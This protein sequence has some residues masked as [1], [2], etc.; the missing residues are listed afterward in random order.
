MDDDSP[1]EEPY[2]QTSQ[3]TVPGLPRA[4]AI[5]VVG[6]TLTAVA[7]IF[8]LSGPA[9][10][11]PSRQ[12]VTMA[13]TT[14]LPGAAQVVPAFVTKGLLASAAAN[15]SVPAL[16]VTTAPA[17]P[18]AAGGPPAAAAAAVVAAPVSH[19]ATAAALH[20]LPGLRAGGAVAVPLPLA[21]LRGGS[22]D[23]GVDYTAPGGTPLF[24]M[25]PGVII[26][27]GIA[28]FG[29]NTPVL[30]ITAGP[31]RGRTVY[32]GHAGP[33]VVPVGAHVTAGQQIGV[34]GSGIVGMSTGPHL[35]V[36]FYPLTGNMGAGA[37]MMAFLNALVGHPT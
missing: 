31:L 15:G 37:A 9:A 34:V 30:L 29:P 27:E 2:P 10:A 8:L 1:V 14:P 4:C 35:E 19:A 24:A 22:I 16:P 26:A 13:R 33:N 21:Y 18:A 20:L 17:P 5:S 25:G 7:A 32:Y 11:G 6:M 36:G 3:W 28:G 12:L 23:Q